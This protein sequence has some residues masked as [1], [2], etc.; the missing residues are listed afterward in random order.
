MHL[1]VI[2]MAMGA[3]KNWKLLLLKSVYRNTEIGNGN[4]TIGIQR[5]R[6]N[7]FIH[8]LISCHQ[9]LH[10][11]TAGYNPKFQSFSGIIIIMITDE[12]SGDFVSHQF[13][14]A[15]LCIGK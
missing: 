10:T 1:S 6:R 4:F 2:C 9:D 11:C 8:T 12:K 3:L 14:A 13:S 15:T 7:G 5:R